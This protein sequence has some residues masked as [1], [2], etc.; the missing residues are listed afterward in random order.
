MYQLFT[1]ETQQPLI[2][3]LFE[4]F[5][6]R[7]F[8]VKLGRYENINLGDGTLITPT[9]IILGL[10]IGIIIAGA[11]VLRDRG[12]LGKF[13]RALNREQCNSPE[14]AKTLA[15]LGFDRSISIRNALRNG[16]RLR[17]VVHCVEWEAFE[18]AVASAEESEKPNLSFRWD[19]S[20]YH[21]YIPA[22]KR[23]EADVRFEKEGSTWKSYVI[24]VIVTVLLAV[25]IIYFLPDLLQML[26]NA[27][28]I[29]KSY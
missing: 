23:I 3:E 25:G 13:V 6:D 17:S 10:M 22:E 4:Y 21:F 29:I 14:T 26:D 12:I 1:L 5:K 18:A 2:S 27:I 11:L 24:L 28:G 9:M 20:T 15:E 8:T 16:K 7:Y 19:N